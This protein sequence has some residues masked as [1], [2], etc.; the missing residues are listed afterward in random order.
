VSEKYGESWP[1]QVNRQK[2]GVEVAGEDENESFIFLSPQR[3]VQISHIELR[4]LQQPI[5]SKR[6]REGT[7]LNSDL[8]ILEP[9]FFSPLVVIYMLRLVCTCGTHICVPASMFS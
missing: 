1:G 9:S 6:E 4:I 3:L 8:K 7:D 2:M 5:Q